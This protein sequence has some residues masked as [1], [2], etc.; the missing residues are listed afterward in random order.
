ML[1]DTEIKEKILKKDEDKERK[2]E[3][4]NYENVHTEMKTPEE[5]RKFKYKNTNTKQKGG[6]N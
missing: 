1:Q 6:R 5:I 4:K 3:E 2:E